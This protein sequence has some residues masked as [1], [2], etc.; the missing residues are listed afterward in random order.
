THD[1]FLNVTNNL[2]LPV[3]IS[4]L[5]RA[6]RWIGIPL[7]AVL[8]FVKLLVEPRVRA[9]SSR[10]HRIL[11]IK[12]AEQGSTVLAYPAIQRAVKMVGRENVYFVVFEENRFVLDLMEI[13]PEENVIPVATS[14]LL[15]LFL[16]ILRAITRCRA[17]GIDAVVDLEFLTR[18][19]AILAFL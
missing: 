2:H 16:S 1:E 12:L 7:C 9:H 19:S 14:S 18:F 15:A 3:R 10:L 11:F 6:D 4:L 17:I 8:T 5:Q 13:V